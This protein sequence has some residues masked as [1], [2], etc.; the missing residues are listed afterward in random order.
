MLF[1]HVR[2][3]LILLGAYFLQYPLKLGVSHYGSAA[4]L[5]ESVYALL[6]FHDKRCALVDG[7]P[8]LVKTVE[9]VEPMRYARKSRMCI[10]G[11]GGG[12]VEYFFRI[13]NIVY[14]LIL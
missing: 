12:S 8:A 6:H 7:Y 4:V 9:A 13:E 5:V 10:D 14:L 3:V 2:E 1:S 11:N